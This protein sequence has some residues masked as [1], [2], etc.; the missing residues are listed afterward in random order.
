MADK[1]ILTRGNASVNTYFHATKKNCNP[2]KAR[3]AAS[4]NSMHPLWGDAA[5]RAYCV[6]ALPRSQKY[7]AS[8]TLSKDNVDAP[9]CPRE[10]AGHEIP[11][12]PDDPAAG[13]CRARKVRPGWQMSED[14][15][16][17][18]ML[19]AIEENCAIASQEDAQWLS[20]LGASGCSPRE[21]LGINRTIGGT[22]QSCLETV[23]N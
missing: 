15:E 4:A 6:D 8:A 7:E 10:T 12:Q 17:R 18:L 5:V 20:V 19:L 14:V 23:L 22:P 9:D 13:C 2:A 3:S 16:I 1:T 11:T 21:A